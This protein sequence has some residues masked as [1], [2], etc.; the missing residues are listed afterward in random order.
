MGETAG[1]LAEGAGPSRRLRG[2]ISTRRND[3]SCARRPSFSAR[4]SSCFRSRAA[5]LASLAAKNED[6]ASKAHVLECASSSSR[7][8][9]AG[10]P[11]AFCA[12]GTRALG[13]THRWTWALVVTPVSMVDSRYVHSCPQLAQ[14]S[15][16]LVL[17]VASGELLELEHGCDSLDS[18]NITDTPQPSHDILLW[19]HS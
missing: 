8:T 1:W 10:Q 9:M 18:R 17:G 13:H 15:L 12:H 2:T 4:S 5:N 6:S 7:V 19:K 16:L 3:H 14:Q 11:R